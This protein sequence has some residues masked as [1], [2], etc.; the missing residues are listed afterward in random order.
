[1]NAQAKKKTADELAKILATTY[2][3][4]LKTQN[5]HWNV[6]G[7]HF[8]DLHSLFQS[9]YEALSE[10]IDEIAERIRALDS[11][12]P[13]TFT[14]FLKHSSIKEA[15]GNP[16]AKDMVRQLLNDHETAAKCAKQVLDAAENAGDDVTV[17]MMVERIQEHD[18]TAW[19]L[20]SI[21]A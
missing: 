17:D 2:T 9:Q 7:P 12:A 19:M 5:F 13:G 20:K 15:S 4:Y 3:L 6:T 11:F 14:T 10:A 1:M 16:K 8:H 18:K 21:L